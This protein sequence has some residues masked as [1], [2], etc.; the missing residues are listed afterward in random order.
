MPVSG[1]MQKVCLYLLLML[2]SAVTLRLV[3]HVWPPGFLLG[4]VGCFSYYVW[5][6]EQA[7]E[8]KMRKAD[9]DDSHC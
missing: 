5:R 3:N 1:P 6:K 9:Q 8:E 2:M 4:I 7:L